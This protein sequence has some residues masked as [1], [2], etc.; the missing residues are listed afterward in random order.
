MLLPGGTPLGALGLAFWALAASR[1]GPK[2]KRIEWLMGGAA[3]VAQTAW[4]GIVFWF[5][6]L[7]LF[8]GF[9]CWPCGVA[10]G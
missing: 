9:G 10:G 2:K 7:W 1:P 4:M 8:V 5:S 3:L 6:I